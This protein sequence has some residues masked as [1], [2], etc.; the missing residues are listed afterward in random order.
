MK[1]R[2]CFLLLV[3]AIAGL[4]ALGA[5]APMSHT[6]LGGGDRNRTGVGRSS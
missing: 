5:G 4:V 1:R 3:S 2:I 6:N